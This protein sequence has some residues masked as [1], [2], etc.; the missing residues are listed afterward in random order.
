MTSTTPILIK[1]EEDS[2]LKIDQ[3]DHY[4]AGIINSAYFPTDLSDYIQLVENAIKG[5]K[6]D[7]E[8]ITGEFIKGTD[9]S[10]HSYKIDYSI[11]HGLF[12][13]KFSVD[14]PLVKHVKD[15]MDYV[16]ERFAELN[17]QI[18]L[19]KDENFVIRNELI[20]IHKQ[21]EDSGYNSDEHDH[22]IYNSK[23]KT[24]P[25]QAASKPRKGKLT[26]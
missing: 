22:D 5:Y 4:Y 13:K 3:G 15:Q 17:V 12:N 9:N 20:S 25:E 11:K 2:I 24:S 6:T 18:K 26:T 10:T 1:K 16:N 21:L 23:Q 7:S 19:L 8:T 14:I